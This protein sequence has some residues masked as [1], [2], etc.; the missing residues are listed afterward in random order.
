MWGPRRRD[1]AWLA[2][3]VQLTTMGIVIV[4]T[5]NILDAPFAGLVTA[6]IVAYFVALESKGPR[7]YTLLA[8]AGLACGGAFLVKGLLAFVLP[9][10]VGG[11]YLAFSRRFRDLF[12]TPWI[13]I[14]VAMAVV[15]PWA[16]AIHQTEPGFWEHFIIGA[17]FQR[18]TAA[19]GNQHSEPFWYYLMVF[20]LMAVPWTFAWPLAVLGLR[21]REGRRPWVLYA[22]C[23]LVVP[24]IFL[25]LSSG[26]LPTYVMPL[27]APV[28]ALTAVGLVMWF[29]GH[30]SKRGFIRY[31][32]AV[33]MGLGALAVALAPFVLTNSTPLWDDGSTWRVYLFAAALCVW[34]GFEAVS[35]SGGR[36]GTSR[37]TWSLA[38][39]VFL[40]AILPAVFPTGLMSNM[41]IPG[42]FLLKHR[43]LLQA[44]PVVTD[45]RVGHGVA[46]VSGDRE[47]RVIG[48]RGDLGSFPEDG[49][50][51]PARF[52]EPSDLSGTFVVVLPSERL[53]GVLQ[54]HAQMKVLERYDEDGLSIARIHYEK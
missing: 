5:A 25:S 41:K 30:P 52:I 8:L 23:W 6:S 10:L 12:L 26:K 37:L 32:P 1:L 15:L 48:E 24:L 18:F 53:D 49:G 38:A 19:D 39:P 16:I 21:G 7:R 44:N 9:A 50:P 33:L 28:A 3:G 13:P 14:L 2:A 43:E 54:S 36:R 20:P 11:V 34:A 42:E 22:T 17:H 46:W 27:M 29:D 40:L 47:M 4:G 45:E 31:I 35:V 51:E